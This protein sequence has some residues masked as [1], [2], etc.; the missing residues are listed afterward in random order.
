MLRTGALRAAG[1]WCVLALKFA[2]RAGA[3]ERAHTNTHTAPHTYAHTCTN[4][5][6]RIS[7][8]IGIIL[9]YK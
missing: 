4:T 3:R 7:M 5:Y 9:M 8:G 1:P 2:A 6:S